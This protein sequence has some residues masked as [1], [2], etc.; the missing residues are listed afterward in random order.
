M[1]EKLIHNY[2][3]LFNGAWFSF[4]I[5]ANSQNNRPWSTENPILDQNLSAQVNKV[6]FGV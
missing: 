3:L 2:F 1:V 5:E 6:V 4:I